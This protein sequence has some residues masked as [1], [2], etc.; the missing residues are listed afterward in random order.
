MPE[1]PPTLQTGDP[2]DD[3]PQV[4]DSLVN[5]A[6]PPKRDEL[7]RQE[8]QRAPEVPKQTRMLTGNATIDATWSPVLLLPAD[9]LRLSLQ[10]WAASDTATDYVR[11]ADDPS[12]VQS[13][14]GSALLYSAMQSAAFDHTG[15]VWVSCPDATGPVRV[16]YLAVTR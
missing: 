1:I 11:V 4:I 12:K 8:T 10:L 7:P 15:P 9:P 3:D 5:P 6:G 2:F 13:L 16:S 14:S